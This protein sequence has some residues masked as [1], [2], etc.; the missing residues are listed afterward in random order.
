MKLVNMMKTILAVDDE[1]DVIYTIK[2]GLE[3]L[4]KEIR[5]IGAN[6]GEKCLEIL[7]NEQLP[8]L[9][10]L[11]IMLP[12]MS[13]W[14]ILEK[15]KEN[16]EWNDIPIIF[17]TARTDTVAKRAGGFLAADYIE[18]PFEVTELKDR[19]D[20]ILKQKYEGKIQ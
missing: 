5:V 9:I 17:L 10:L 20:E 8:D 11:D 13:G 16:K 19:I 15:I 12:D 4:D 18:K 3:K 2:L 1:Q 7:K 6:S 14:Q